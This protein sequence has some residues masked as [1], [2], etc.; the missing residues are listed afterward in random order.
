MIEEEVV[1]KMKSL[2]F[3]E[4]TQICIDKIQEFD[5]K[6]FGVL[7]TSDLK[8]ALISVSFAVG[9]SELEI[10]MICN[11]LPV[12]PFNRTLYNSIGEVLQKARFINLKLSIQESQATELHQQL[13]EACKQEERFLRKDL[14]SDDQALTGELPVGNFNKVLMNLSKVT[15]SRLQT[16][17]IMAE[18]G[19]SD[20]VVNYHSFLP[21]VSKTIEYMFEPKA[22]RQRAGSLVMTFLLFGR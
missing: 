8:K 6:K 1:T 21:V 18:S 19:A 22:L 15:L 20:G 14:S 3:D 16:L 13:L 11:R 2:N 17:V 10:L 4:I 7:R 5:P 9:L 12:D